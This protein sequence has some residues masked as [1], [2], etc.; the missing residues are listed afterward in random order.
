MWICKYHHISV[1]KP[2]G[3]PGKSS[4]HINP[5]IKYGFTGTDKHVWR[6]TDR[7]NFYIKFVKRLLVNCWFKLR[8]PYYAEQYLPSSKVLILK[9][10]PIVEINVG[11]NV[12]SANRNIMQVLP[13]PLSPIRR[14]LK[15]WSKFFAMSR[16]LFSFLCCVTVSNVMHSEERLPNFRDAWTGTGSHIQKIENW[17][18]PTRT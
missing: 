17:N 13:T 1:H 2:H 14:S 10:I 7:N 16:T 15:K 11:L 18:I 12:L 3:F 5:N 6:Q 8:T 9:S 4:V